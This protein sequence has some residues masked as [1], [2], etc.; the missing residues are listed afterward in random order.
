MSSGTLS[1]TVK[2]DG[3]ELCSLRDAAGAEMLW[4]GA[5]VWPRH[6]PV[7]FPIVGRLKDDT[8]RHDGKSYRLT[9]HGFARDRRF[10]WLN[11]SA[12]ACRLVLHEDTETR[13][14]YPFAFRLEIAYALDDDVLEQRFTLTN[15]G[16][17]VLPASLGA[18]PGFAWPLTEGV[19]KA[20]H[21]LEF[22]E[23]EPAP[24]RRLTEGLLRDALE[25]TPIVGQT[26]AL[27]PALFATDAV[28]LPEPVSRSVRYTAPGAPAVELAW[29]GFRQL[30]IWSREGG[31]FLCIE[32]WYGTASPPD[33]DGEFSDK[34]GLML[35][36]PDERRTLSLRIR[37]C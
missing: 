19:E 34:P 30:G 27:E 18:H 32:P 11:R 26:L 22:A 28:I 1:A 25:P 35:I 37:L 36:P 33:F 12:T 5:P 15:P 13:A 3:A 16:R 20:A 9:Q 23:P 2:A 6:A 7:L 8:L 4:Q 17:G 24:V 21:V 14:M 29:E 31:N 10:A